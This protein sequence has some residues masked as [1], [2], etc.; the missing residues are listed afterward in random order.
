MTLERGDYRPRLQWLSL[1]VALV[2]L[3]IALTR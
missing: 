3:T 2:L 1:I